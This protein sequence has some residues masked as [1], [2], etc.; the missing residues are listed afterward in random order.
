MT[1]IVEIGSSGL[2]ASVNSEGAQ[3]WTLRDRMG[4]DLL[5]DGDPK[6]WPSRAPILFPVIGE[7][8]GGQVRVGGSAYPM[9]RHG[10]ARD[11][12]FDVAERSADRVTFVLRESEETRTRYPFAF[13][14][15]LRFRASGASLATEVTARNTGSSAMPAS[16]G[17]HP[18]F[19]WPLTP[20]T[21]RND[22][23]CL[24]EH[25]EPD[26]IRQPNVATGL[27][28][29]TDR[30]SPVKARRLEMHDGLFES[31][32][33]VF[34]RHRSRSL[35]YGAPGATGIKADFPSMP[36]LGLWTR[37]GF[38]FFCIEPWHGLADET[39]ADGELEKR[40]GITLLEPGASLGSAMTV[41]IGTMPGG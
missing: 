25:E 4:R 40:P 13:E 31:G 5:W 16:F 35:W 12:A 26:P 17:F 11:C 37:P 21:A 28:L 24:F 22:H 6:Y 23:I 7:S 33:L 14:L 2:S 19:R 41:T 1:E 30:P 32:A 34:V 29:P 27:M 8:P 10:F 20:G 15:S 38:P 3:L 18:A 36:H 9:N 39:G